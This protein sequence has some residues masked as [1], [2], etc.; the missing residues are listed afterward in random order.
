MAVSIGCGDSGN[1]ASGNQS[2]QISAD[3]PT[4]QFCQPNGDGQ[5]V[6]TPNTLPANEPGN[7]QNM[8]G[9]SDLPS[10]PRSPSAGGVDGA[11]SNAAGIPTIGTFGGQMAMEPGS[12]GTAGSMA[13]SGGAP[14]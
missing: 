9:Q 8:G 11:S 2:C 6:C 1:E 5:R 10:T 13:P 4:G 3:C 7:P 12:N 14:A